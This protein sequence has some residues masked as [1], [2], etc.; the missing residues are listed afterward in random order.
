MTEDLEL[1]GGVRVTIGLAGEATEGAFALLV[2]RPPVGWSLPPHRHRNESETIHVVAGRFELVVEGE[3]RELG[4]G[5][6]VHVP[7][8]TLHEGR[9]IG[10]DEG[11][12]V[13]VFSPAGV[14]GWFR[15]AA[16]EPDR[17]G[18]LALEYGWEFA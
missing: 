10:D 14:E 17:A 2:D 9:N 8:G 13:I 3:R 6:S 1:P 7:R 16:A 4:P 15:A 12:R 18:E 11:R 5:D